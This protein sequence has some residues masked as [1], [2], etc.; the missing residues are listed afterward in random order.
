V[1]QI[2]QRRDITTAVNAG[3]GI[4][5]IPTAITHEI[6]ENSDAVPISGLRQRRE[7]NIMIDPEVARLRRLRSEAL[8]VREIARMYESSRWAGSDSL[9][10]RCACAGWRIARIVSGRLRSH[11]YAEYQK[12]VGAAALLSNRLRAFGL[13]IAHNKPARA[14]AVLEAH[15]QTLNRQLDDAIRLGWSSD[16][17]AAL[18]RAHVEIKSLSAALASTNRGAA[19]EERPVALPVGSDR[20]VGDLG[21]ALEGDWP[22]LAL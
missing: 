18:N 5:V 3:T 8:L 10:D 13:A 7:D 1:S 4:G 2:Q 16:F 6:L 22:Y 17:S 20:V 21:P 15:V 19:A 12:D 9:L 14:F 11:P